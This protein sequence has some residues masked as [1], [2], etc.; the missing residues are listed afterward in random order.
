MERV[1]MGGMDPALTK[2]LGALRYGLYFLTT[3]TL[4][5]PQGLLVSWVSQVSGQPPLIMAAVRENRSLLA[6]L[7][8]DEAFALN[9]LPASGQE[10]LARLA[11]PA[12]KRLAGVGLTAGTLGLPVLAEGLGALCC[13]VREIWRPGDHVLFLGQVEGVLWRG[14]PGGG[15]G[16]DAGITGH[17]YLGLS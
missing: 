4:E 16:M 13:R 15:P 12:D 14:G 7:E 1:K 9:L 3:G 6:K 8:E 2:A 10:L 17:A 11:R 5:V